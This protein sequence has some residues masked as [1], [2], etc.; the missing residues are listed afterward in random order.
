MRF[1]IKSNC[2]AHGRTRHNR[3]LKP[4]FFDIEKGEHM[5]DMEK[6]Q[7]AEEEDYEENDPPEDDE[8]R[9]DEPPLP[10]KVLDC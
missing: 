8:T 7:V 3:S 6:G 5:V 1:A 10:K 2:L 9:I 4:L